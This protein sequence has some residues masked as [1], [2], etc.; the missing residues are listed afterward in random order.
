MDLNGERVVRKMITIKVLL[1]IQF[2]I[3]PNLLIF[4]ERNDQSHHFITAKGK[5][6][7]MLWKFSNLTVNIF[8]F[9]Y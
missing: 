7:M 8:L 3:R 5:T 9:N 4:K 6:H 2:K 1:A